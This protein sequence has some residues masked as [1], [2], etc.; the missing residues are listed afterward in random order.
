M[1][2]NGEIRVFKWPRAKPEMKANREPVRFE[3][4]LAAWVS[5]P[6]GTARHGTATIAPKRS[7]ICWVISDGV[8]RQRLRGLVSPGRATGSAAL[9]SARTGTSSHAPVE[10]GSEA[11][12]HEDVA[13]RRPDRGEQR[14]ARD[15]GPTQRLQGGEKAARSD[16]ARNRCASRRADDDRA[17]LVSQVQPSADRDRVGDQGR[18]GS[19]WNVAAPPDTVRRSEDDLRKGHHKGPE[20]PDGQ[21]PC[22][23]FGPSMPEPRLCQ[24]MRYRPQ[25][26]D[27]REFGMRRDRSAQLRAQLLPKAGRLG[28]SHSR[29][30][31]VV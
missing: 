6:T 12:P 1:V 9:P 28:S 27:L 15:G 25:P 29:K 30:K 2:L 14:H 22:Q 11:Q 10:P 23:R 21:T 4:A 26:T 13:G 19:D 24:A 18:S 7:V 8:Q 5:L 31:L 17:D 16:V 20:Q 3:A